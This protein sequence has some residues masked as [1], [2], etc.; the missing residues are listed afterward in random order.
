MHMICNKANYKLTVSD[1]S[2]LNAN[3][4]TQTNFGWYTELLI[5]SFC[6]LVKAKA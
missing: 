6:L 5:P 3:A 4:F 1:K 2:Y